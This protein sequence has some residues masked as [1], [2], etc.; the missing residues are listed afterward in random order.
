M[1]STMFL[2]SN[3]PPN[4]NDRPLTASSMDSLLS[5]WTSF[6]SRCL[7]WLRH[8]DY[9]KHNQEPMVYAKACEEQTD[10]LA[11]LFRWRRF[12]YGLQPAP[13]LDTICSRSVKLIRLQYDT[14]YIWAAEALD[15]TRLGFDDHNTKFESVV[16][17][18][19]D[20]LGQD[21][22]HSENSVH[23]RHVP[24]QHSPAPYTGYTF[25]SFGVVAVLGFVV[26]RCRLGTVRRR[27]LGLLER[28]WWRENGWSTIACYQGGKALVELEEQG[29]IRGADGELYIPAESRYYWGNAR[30]ENDQPAS[31]KL[32][33]TFAQRRPDEFGRVAEVPV[34]IDI[35]PG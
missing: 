12:I 14:L 5:I 11:Y 33:C 16:K 6:S 29:G 1:P 7:V 22:G 26:T 28:I 2:D 8:T 27:A 19:A 23:D 21:F 18:C 3:P 20:L 31:L 9:T 35:S 15:R 32:I 25:E 30:W 13:E 4:W 34:T 17:L 10:L 24:R